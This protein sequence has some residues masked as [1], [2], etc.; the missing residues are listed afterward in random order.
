[1]SKFEV[2]L[3]ELKTSNNP[4]DVL[5]ASSLGSCIGL[6]VY[7]PIIRV[8][9]LLHYVLPYSKIDASKA[10]TIPGMFADTGVPLLFREMY[11]LGAKKERMLVKVTGGSHILGD[12]RVFDMGKRN[13][14]MLRKIFLKNKVKIAGEDVGGNENRNLVLNIKDGRCFVQVQGE[15]KEL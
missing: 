4:Q 2:S 10:L 1:M 9:G 8:G 11:K 13:Y 15:D 3:A 6:A 5:V 14:V 12:S 7:D